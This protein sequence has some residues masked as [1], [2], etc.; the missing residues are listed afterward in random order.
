MVSGTAFGAEPYDTAPA[1][2]PDGEYIYFYTYRHDDGELYRMRPDGSEQTRLTTTDYN[3]W[4]VHPLADGETLLVASG[5][6]GKF[7]SRLDLEV[8]DGKVANYR[9]RLIPVFADVI[10]PDPEMA[11]RFHIPV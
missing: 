3:E 11:A 10:R 7:L 5:S 9:Y 4:W 6:H 8:K 1:W 2:S